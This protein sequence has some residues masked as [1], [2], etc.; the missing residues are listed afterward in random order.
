MRATRWRPLATCYAVGGTCGHCAH[1][2]G[3]DHDVVADVAGKGLASA[4]V[5]ISF[6]SAFHAMV[7]SG[8]PLV[9]DC[10]AHE[11]LHYNEGEDRGGAMT[12]FFAQLDPRRTVSRW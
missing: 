7:N 12:A 3:R 4:L 11:L 10:D 8:V 1:A 6:R 5:S 9:G 2:L